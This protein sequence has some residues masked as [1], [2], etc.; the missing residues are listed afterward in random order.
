MISRRRGPYVG[1]RNAGSGRG[2]Q[3]CRHERGVECRRPGKGVQ[4]GHVD[5][6]PGLALPVKKLTHAVDSTCNWIICCI[7]IYSACSL[8]GF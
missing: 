4:R 2:V 5:G 7:L 3:R 1:A 6:H 8:V